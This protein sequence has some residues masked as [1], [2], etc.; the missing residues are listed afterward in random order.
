V[1]NVTQIREIRLNFDL[2][3]VMGTHLC[4]FVGNIFAK[5]SLINQGLQRISKKTSKKERKIVDVFLKM[6]S[7]APPR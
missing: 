2:L 7:L 6:S 5:N 3:R 4:R 1:G